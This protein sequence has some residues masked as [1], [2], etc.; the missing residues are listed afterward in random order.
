M[1][2]VLLE[3][4]D[5]GWWILES[6]NGLFFFFWCCYVLLSLPLHSQHFSHTRFSLRLSPG[7]VFHPDTPTPHPA[8]PCEG[9]LITSWWLL[10][11]WAK[12]IQ[13]WGGEMLCL[14]WEP[15]CFGAALCGVFFLLSWQWSTEWNMFTLDLIRPSLYAFWVLLFANV[16]GV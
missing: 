9:Q 11:W 5:R 7:Q 3:M 1:C 15:T 16:L 10:L 13:D 14:P 4:L 6:G 12:G 2:C 8:P